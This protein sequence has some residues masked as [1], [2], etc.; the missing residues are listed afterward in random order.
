MK[1]QPRLQI[2]PVIEHALT[3]PKIK[4]VIRL[5]KRIEDD[6]NLSETEDSDVELSLLGKKIAVQETK[7]LSYYYRCV[8]DG[9]PMFIKHTTDPRLWGGGGFIEAKS[10][11]EAQEMLRASG[12]DWAEVV[13]FK[14]G[15]TG[16]KDMYFV[17]DWKDK[18]DMLSLDELGKMQRTQAQERLFRQATERFATL[19]K[20]FKDFYDFLPFNVWIDAS[21]GKLYLFDLHR[22]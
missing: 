20:L 8:L 10:N 13:K 4:K 17:A 2:D 11:Q 16:K 14:L 22:M 6:P 7:P 21:S 5:V 9:Q 1:E 18:E 3:L 19:K 15:Y 12:I